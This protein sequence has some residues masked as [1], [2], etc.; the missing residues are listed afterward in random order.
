MMGK[1]FRM[2]FTFWLDLNKSDESELA[3]IVDTLKSQRGYASAIRDG[4]RLVWE[5]RQGK[6][7]HLLKLFPF[8]RE[9]LQADNSEL[10]T[11][12]TSMMHN[13]TTT[14]LPP[15]LVPTHDTVPAVGKLDESKAREISINNALAALDDF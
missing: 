5:L 15:R 13:P 7:E 4:L 9:A 1:S 14:P 2:R 11:L 8:V 6:T 10:I 3:D 12:I